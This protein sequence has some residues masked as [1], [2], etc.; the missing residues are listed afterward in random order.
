MLA[1]KLK[2]SKGEKIEEGDDIYEVNKRF[3]STY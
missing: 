3:L 1:N 2:W